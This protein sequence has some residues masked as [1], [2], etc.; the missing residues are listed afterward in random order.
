MIKQAS[1]IEYIDFLA[2]K[3]VQLVYIDPPYLTGKTFFDNKGN[4]AYTDK[5]VTA[6]KYVCQNIKSKLKDSGLICVQVDHRLQHHVRMWLDHSFGEQ[7][8][9]NQIIWAY[10]TGGSTKKHLSRKHDYL[11]V[12]SKTKNHTFN[13]QKEKSYNRDFKPYRFKGV[14]EFCDSDGKW[15][16][17]ANMKDVWLDI[18]AVGRTSKER[19][20]Y[21]TQKPLKLLDRV[22]QL[23][24]NEGDIVCD[25][26]CGSGTTLESAKNN[27]RIP[28]GCDI[29]EN[30][31]KICIERI[32][33]E[34]SF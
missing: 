7:N 19:N 23:F 30:A 24:S 34:S 27:K 26:F 18:P 15:Y 2:D 6:L 9:V 25:L 14:E 29:N 32:G 28:F 31:I 22:I 13:P 8:F 33:C 21:P 5:D 10:N 11:I 20:G 17:M 12:Y 4:V 16:T 1:A 3:S